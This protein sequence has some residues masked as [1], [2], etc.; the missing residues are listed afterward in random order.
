ML[1][2]KLKHRFNKL[3]KKIK[4]SPLVIAVD[5]DD[6]LFNTDF[7]TII[8]P[9]EDIIHFCKD[10]QAQGH[11]LILN[12]CR[13]GVVLNEAIIACKRVGLVFDYVNENVPSRIQKYGS[14][15]RKIGADLY[16]DDKAINPIL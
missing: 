13:E 10:L 16:L 11:I 1:K 6:T 9:K 5:F 4:N 15:C 14:D 12:T 2:N 3:K 7:P 8:S